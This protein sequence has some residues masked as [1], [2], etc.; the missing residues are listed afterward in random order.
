MWGYSSRTCITKI[1]RPWKPQRR[2]TRETNSYGKVKIMTTQLVFDLT[3]ENQFSAVNVAI[4][5]LL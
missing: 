1:E 5:F 3:E 4:F 2:F